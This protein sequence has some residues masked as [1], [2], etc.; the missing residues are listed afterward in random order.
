MTKC[1]YLFHR[2]LF[3]GITLAAQALPPPG[4]APKLR[5]ITAPPAGP[6]EAL[7]YSTMPSTNA[8]CPEMAL[9]GDANTYFQ[10]VYG[11]DDGDDFEVILSRAIPVSSLQVVTG[12]AAGQDR[13]TGGVL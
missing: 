6:V 10:T 9:D 11:M 4:V 5:G 8:H 13:L 1:T 2:A 12:D 7:V 3:S